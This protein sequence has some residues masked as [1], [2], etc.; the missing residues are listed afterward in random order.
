MTY[1]IETV[2]TDNVEVPVAGALVYVYDALGLTAL[3]DVLGAHLDNPMITDE[4]GHAVGYVAASGV[5][6]LKHYYAGKDRYIE[7]MPVGVDIN[8]L[9]TAAEGIGAIT[10]NTPVIAS[11][12]LL[13]AVTAPAPGQSAFLSEAGREGWWK[14][15]A[16]DYSAQVTADVDQ[17]NYL[18]SSSNPTGS[19]KVWARP[20]TAREYKAAWWGLQ[21]DSGAQDNQTPINRMLTQVE[22]YSQIKFDAGWFKTNASIELSTVEGLEISGHGE[23]TIF[24]PD[25][26]VTAAADYHVWFVHKD[27]TTFRRV[28]AMNVAGQSSPGESCGFHFSIFPTVPT[29]HGGNP[30]RCCLIEC[31]GDN[32]D[33]FARLGYWYD[34]SPFFMAATSE[35]MIRDCHAENIRGRSVEVF[36]ASK[37]TILG[38]HFKMKD[39]LDATA[40]DPESFGPMVR[41]IGATNNIVA[42]N[43]FEHVRNTNTGRYGIQIDAGGPGPTSAE[44][45]KPVTS[46]FANNQFMHCYVVFDMDDVM[47]PILITGNVATRDPTLTDAATFLRMFSNQP[48]IY[49]GLNQSIIA[50]GNVS[51]GYGFHASLLGACKHIRLDGETHYSNAYNSSR[52]ADFGSANVPTTYRMLM[53]LLDCVSL[54]TPLANIEP[55]N[56]NL[57]AGDRVKVDKCRLTAPGASLANLIRDA[58]SDAGSFVESDDWFSNEALDA[59]LYT[60]FRTTNFDP[61]T[62]RHV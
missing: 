39:H 49:E 36:N 3:T 59:A 48:D 40:V 30:A 61:F 57:R 9:V 28:K 24:G 14:L 2:V 60:Q 55:I 26:G 52:F 11:R 43:I 42:N 20:R 16:G 33:T 1:A 8:A 5:Y 21:P 4:L 51:N 53:E 50:R 45:I 56:L 25:R 37:N 54:R 12:A 62:G 13:S 35:T 10:V 23:G 58:G 18:A 38:N 27:A 29:A 47:G 19:T 7:Q 15:L 44:N 41:C 32:L 22:P 34:N 31:Y 17:A 46:I 6:T